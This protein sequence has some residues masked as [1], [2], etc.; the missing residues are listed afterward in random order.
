MTNEKISE[1]KGKK[2]DKLQKYF[3]KSYTPQQMEQ[4]IIRLLDG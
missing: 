2:A 4:I 3:P 1:S